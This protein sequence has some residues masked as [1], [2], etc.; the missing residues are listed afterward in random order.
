MMGI[1]RFSLLERKCVVEK[2][3]WSRRGVDVGSRS[4][5]VG[6][7]R[8]GDALFMGSSMLASEIDGN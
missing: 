1:G 2:V 8:E 4:A 3:G 6:C 7:A 5:V